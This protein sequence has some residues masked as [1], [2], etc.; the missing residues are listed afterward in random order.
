MADLIL[1]ISLLLLSALFSGSEVSIFSLR[2]TEVQKIKSRE[3]IFT[4][5]LRNLLENK[6]SALIVILVGNL[7]VNVFLSSKVSQL[8]MQSFGE[9]GLAPSV[10]FV[11]AL[12]IVFSEITPKTIALKN[13]SNFALLSAPILVFLKRTVYPVIKI[14]DQISEAILNVLFGKKKENED[15]DLSTDEL[16]TMVSL[17]EQQGVFH[18]WEKKLIEQIFEFH[19]VYAVERM[20]PRPDILAVELNESRLS[21]SEKLI[22]FPYSKMPVY[23]KD[24]DTIV[25]YFQV[26]DFLLFPEKS[27]EEI[28]K[29]VYLIPE[30]KPLDKLL[31]EM[32][33]KNLKLAV[34]LDEYGNTQGIISIEEVLESIFGEW[35]DPEK[36]TEEEEIQTLG[37]GLFKIDASVTCREINTHIGEDIFHDEE[38][39]PG[40]TIAGFLVQQ[41]NRIPKVGDKLQDTNFVISVLEMEDR[42]I[43]W[44]ELNLLLSG[45]EQS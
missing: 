21:I 24:L 36:I 14:L 15:G 32:Q 10:F 7:I 28:M 25:A 40:I 6:S 13:A 12:L 8:A 11:T 19:E 33:T 38:L 5:S 35:R 34:L 26:K 17:G 31:Q 42:R 37:K 45:E 9:A 16:T 4:R 44:I 1:L 20:V 30:R 2:D 29:P 3:N 43:L 22:D 39:E 23:E 27:L 18:G 41:L